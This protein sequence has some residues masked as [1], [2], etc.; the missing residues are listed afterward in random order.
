MIDGV[1]IRDLV[2][3]ADEHGFLYEILR[4]DWPEFENFGQ[5]YL[6]VTYPG[7]IKGWHYHDLQSDHFCVIKGMA[8]IVLYDD[9]EGSPTRY[10]LMEISMG[11][12]RQKLLVFPPKVLHGVIALNNEPMWLLNFP[13]VK[14]NPENPDEHRMPHDMPIRRKDGTTAPYEWLRC[15]E[16]A[17]LK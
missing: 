12:F 16:G 8:K 17:G 7:V 1:M 14:Y 10:E 13:D 11:E 5:A 3:H 4:E 9:R 2:V 15:T 6:T